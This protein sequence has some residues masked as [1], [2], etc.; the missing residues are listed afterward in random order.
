MV[1]ILT[2]ITSSNK[3]NLG[4]AAWISFNGSSNIKFT[5]LVQDHVLYHLKATV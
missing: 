5:Y 2:A 1:L 3:L 4:P